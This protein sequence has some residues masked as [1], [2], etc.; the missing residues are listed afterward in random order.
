M[1]PNNPFKAEG[2]HSH[3]TSASQRE[4]FSPDVSQKAESSE[5]VQGVS[6]ERVA[7]AKSNQQ[8]SIQ[9]KQLDKLKG[10]TSFDW[11]QIPPPFMAELLMQTPFRGGAG[12]PDYYLSAYQAYRFAIRC[13]E[14]GL[15]P[16]STEV[17]Y[18]PKNNMT[19]TTFEGKLKLARLNKMNLGPPRFEEK[20]RPFPKGRSIG[21]FDQDLGISCRMTTGKAGDDAEYTAW[22]SEWYVPTSPVWKAKPDHMLRVRSAEKCLSFAS[23]LGVSELMGD[24]DLQTGAEVA[25]IMPEVSATEFNEVK[26]N[27]Q[28]DK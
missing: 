21:G 11:K 19:N 9:T 16:L 6:S 2:Q 1:N 27:I 22:L 25:A 13:Y 4:I 18:N 28:G 14:L 24:Q 5:R 3:S 7:L 15:S 23:G 17:W 20:R 10:I 8:E 26:P 12:E